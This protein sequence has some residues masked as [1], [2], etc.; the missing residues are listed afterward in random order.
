MK[1]KN[2]GKE[3][4]V[5]KLS[6]YASGNFCSRSC[7]NSYS[8]KYINNDEI[9]IVICVI[10]GKEIEVKKRA[11]TKNCK[12][13]ICKKIKKCKYCGE[14]ICKRPDICKLHQLFPTLIKYFGFDESKIGTI[15]VYEEFDRIKNLLFEDYWDSELSL[16]KITE[17]YDYP[18]CKNLNKVFKC[19][20]IKRRSFSDSVTN[21]IKQNLLLNITYINKFKHGWHT[22]WNDKQV[23]Y[24]SS[25][26]LDFALQL[27]EQKI[28][29]E[30]ENLRI[31]YWDS[32]KLHQRIA[33][34]DFYLPESNTIVE[35]KSSYWYNEQNM[36][37]RVK[38]YKE[39]GYNFKLILNM[40][41]Q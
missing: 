3:V 20:N 19:L 33:I 1:C 27:D 40:V 30:M 34:P 29:Y 26:E 21:A 39:H 41:E 28:D 15:H 4:D 18:N 32:Q 2:C 36:N 23:F 31:V 16:Q 14:T 12:C 7:A 9:K 22:T 25:Y 38:V 17:K 24:R 35:I 5:T 8:S 11:G 37:D 13:D 6:K 10:C